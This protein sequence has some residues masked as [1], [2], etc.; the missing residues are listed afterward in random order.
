[1]ATDYRGVTQTHR[2]QRGEHY[3]LV[4]AHPA[5]SFMHELSSQWGP[6][7]DWIDA[8]TW[9]VPLNRT[10]PTPDATTAALD[11]VVYPAGVNHTVAELVSGIVGAATDL[12]GIAQYVTVLSV[13]L[14]TG[15]DVQQ[16]GAV[17]GD[18]SRL[19]AANDG[20]R[21]RQSADPVLN[22][23]GDLKVAA[24]VLIVAVAVIAVVA[25]GGELKRWL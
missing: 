15:S 6:I 19:D 25:G 18:D 1:M 3:R 24:L 16:T 10:P 12:F 11:V 14:L 9:V 21:E 23:F 5:A 22:L 13:S 7:L 2:M 4:L 17:S 20:E 8:A